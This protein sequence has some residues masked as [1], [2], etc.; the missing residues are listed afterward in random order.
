MS[1]SSVL[2]ESVIRC[3]TQ[4]RLSLL[5][6]GAEITPH[7]LINSHVLPGVTFGVF[8]RTTDC[9]CRYILPAQILFYNDRQLTAI[10]WFSDLRLAAL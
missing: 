8:I 10:N 2:I 5:I 9:D 7:R 3:G 4:V 6:C 1:D